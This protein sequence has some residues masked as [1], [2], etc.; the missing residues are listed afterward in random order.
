M[1]D[2]MENKKE[3]VR[4]HKLFWAG[5]KLWQVQSPAHSISDCGRNLNNLM[6]RNSGLKKAPPFYFGE[7]HPK[8]YQL[9]IEGR[10][11]EQKADEKRHNL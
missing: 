6:Q 3:P 8:Q 2:S 4:E 11:Y 1:S 10:D 7:D 9:N 5:E